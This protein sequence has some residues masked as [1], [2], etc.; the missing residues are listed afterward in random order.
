[1]K[2][3]AEAGTGELKMDKY[4]LVVYDLHPVDQDYPKIV[5]F[6]KTFDKCHKILQTTWIIRDSTVNAESLL[7]QLKNYID[8]NDEIFVTEIDL[9]TAWKFNDKQSDEAMNAVIDS[10]LRG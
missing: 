1:M 5:R 3:P 10:F 2:N 7:A 9:N 6:L 8:E 4:Y